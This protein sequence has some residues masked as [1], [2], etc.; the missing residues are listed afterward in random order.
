[1][2]GAVPPVTAPIVTVPFGL[3]QV[4]LTEVTARAVGA[5]LAFT[6]TEVLKIQPFTYFTDT[7]YVP[8]AI[9]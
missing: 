8:A 3:P 1:M 9:V 4:E 6:L 2:Y 5:G 7:G